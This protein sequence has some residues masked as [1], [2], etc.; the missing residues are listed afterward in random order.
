VDALESLLQHTM[1]AART[2]HLGAREVGNVAYGAACSSTGEQMGALFNALARAAEQR[3]DDFNVQGLT[4]MAW[5]FVTARQLDAQLL[6]CLAR[7][8]E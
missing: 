6:L 1:L 4:N 2:G 3:P 7:A 8:A 5:A